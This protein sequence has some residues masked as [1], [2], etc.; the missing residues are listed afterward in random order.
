MKKLLL[1]IAICFSFVGAQAQESIK[2]E[3]NFHL[4]LDLQTKYI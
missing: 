1:A 2:R 3:S 4:G